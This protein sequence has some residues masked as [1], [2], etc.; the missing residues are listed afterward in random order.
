[1]EVE[2]LLIVQILIATGS[3]CQSPDPGQVVIIIGLVTSIIGFT[4]F[5]GGLVI[6]PLTML[7]I[8]LVISGASLESITAAVLTHFGTSASSIEVVSKMVDAIRSVLG[9]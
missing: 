1:V 8:E 9:C 4:F 3:A 2:P 6:C 7:L 5:S